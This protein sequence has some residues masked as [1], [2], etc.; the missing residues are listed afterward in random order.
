MDKNHIR[1]EKDWLET[2]LLYWKLTKRTK[3]SEYTCEPWV[4]RQFRNYKTYKTVVLIQKNIIYAIHFMKD[5]EI[6]SHYIIFTILIIWKERIKDYYY[7]TLRIIL[8][9]VHYSD[10]IYYYHLKRW[11]SL[12]T[13]L[14]YYC[15][16]FFSHV[17][18]RRYRALV[19]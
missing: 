7:S 17:R 15:F 16:Y 10:K 14:F 1:F 11:N 4:T 12:V 19:M 6:W 9:I 5:K 2:V 13:E 18:L 8:L 3:V